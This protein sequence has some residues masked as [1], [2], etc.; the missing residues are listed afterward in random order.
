MKNLSKF[1]LLLSFL[2]LLYS[3]FVN[4]VHAQV[5]G[6]NLSCGKTGDPE[7]HSLRPY[8]AAPCGDAPK[9]RYCSNRLVFFESFD[10]AGKGDCKPTGTPG[11]FT[12]N[13]D[14]QVEPHDLFVELDDSQFPIMGN[15]E[16]VKNVENSEDL[17]DDATKVNEY[18]SWYLSGV[19][20]KAE[21]KEAT[22]EQIVNFSGPV[23]KLLPS[24]I[25]D[26]QRIKTIES[27]TNQTTYED[28][29]TGKDITEAENHD[30]IVVDKLRLSSWSDGSL[31]ALNTFFNWLGTDIWNKKYPPLPW[32]FDE[33]ILYRKAY[34]EWQG[35]NCAIL[36]LVGLQCV[37]TLV[38]D[39]W[40]E[41]WHFVPLSN[42]SDKKGAN[43]LITIDG[44]SYDPSNGTEIDNAFHEDY[45]NAP[46]FFAHTQEVQDLSSLLKKTYAPSGVAS[47]PVP[48]TTEFNNCSVLNVR[49]NKGDNLFPGDTPEISATGVQYHINQAECK[50]T[51]KEELCVK[52][53]QN[54]DY[55][56]VTTC[57][58]SD[59]ECIAEVGVIFELGTKTPWAKEIFQNTVAGSD[60]TF[61]KMFPKVEEGAPVSC[62]ADIPT[63]TSVTYNPEKSEKPKGGEY[64][65]KV[66]KNPEDSLSG[67]P[68]LTFPHIGSI[69]EYFLNGIQT[70][71]RPQGYGK[72]IVSGEC[73]ECGELP[74]L[75]KAVGSCKLGGVSPRVGE[76]PDSLKEIISAAAETYKVPPNLIIG[77]MYGEGLFN[78]G[79]YEWTDEN[80]KAW[81]TCTPIPDCNDGEGDDGFMGFFSGTWDNI[82]GEI[83]DDLLALDPARQKPMRC[84]LLDAIYGAAYNLH[85]SADGG[86]G[87][88]KSCFGIDLV[89]SVPSS[90]DWRED[91]Q[92]ASAIQAS[93]NGHDPECFTLQNSCATGGGKD[94]ACLNGDSCE[95]IGSR[96]PTSQSS[97][98]ACFWD[99]AHGN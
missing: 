14:F 18:A 47:E 98:F 65:F 27:A 40:A 55:D 68:E 21:N 1:S 37:D 16:D 66:Q 70:A 11:S 79:R 35:K 38:S 53:R 4:N 74:E 86:G 81:A 10:V 89:G 22:D 80:V 57:I 90:C 59:L 9:A 91:G 75:P 8:Q 50:E 72:P 15:T 6:I 88:P 67:T 44:P 85:D 23:K 69:Y 34:N 49:T 97:H 5:P 30:Q 46:L 41:L 82:A 43:Y 95:T 87:M 56:G 96:Y 3:V 48:D 29:D 39:K 20:D 54:P 78:P 28:E 26:E 42:N 62:I 94:A 58:V 19:N 84:N 32:Q 77:Q 12:C 25:Q 33:E 99:V 71:L 83:D 73:I 93:E 64:T 24:M 92:Y 52:N 31:S 7:F 76:I 45:T 61:R 17:I 63:V 36:P 60:G 2:L 51:I 13:P